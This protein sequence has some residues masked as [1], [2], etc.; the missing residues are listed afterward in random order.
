MAR[1]N[2]QERFLTIRSL[3]TKTAW[4]QLTQRFFCAAFRSPYLH[5]ENGCGNMLSLDRET[6]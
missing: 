4:P 1:I 3:L 5:P 2:Q 6:D